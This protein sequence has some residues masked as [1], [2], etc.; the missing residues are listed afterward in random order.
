MPRSLGLLSASPRTSG[1]SGCFAHRRRLKTA[2]VWCKRIDLFSSGIP[3]HFHSVKA[4]KSIQVG[5]APPPSDANAS[6]YLFCSCTCAGQLGLRSQ[7]TRKTT[8]S[9]AS[10]VA[11]G[12]SSLRGP[13]LYWLLLPAI[14]KTES[15]AHRPAP[16]SCHSPHMPV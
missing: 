4:A 2:A 11:A 10:D 13:A 1:L 3:Q 7:P 15:P 12:R 14:R 5:K 8:S 9:V 6:R 16:V